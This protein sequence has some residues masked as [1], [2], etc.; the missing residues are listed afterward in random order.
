M[1]LKN[2]LYHY[3]DASALIEIVRTGKLWA[4]DINYMNDSREG[5]VAIKH[6]ENILKGLLLT[7]LDID[8]YTREVFVSFGSAGKRPYIA[9]F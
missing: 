7:N 5:T 1:N 8:D 2:H 3:T 4:T 9:A 6:I